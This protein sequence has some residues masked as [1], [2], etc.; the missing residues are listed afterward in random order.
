MTN[1]PSGYIIRS[2][3]KEDL[4]VMKK[5]VAIL[6]IFT[7]LLSLTGC[8]SYDGGDFD[9][10]GDPS[11]SGGYVDILGGDAKSEIA[12]APDGSTSS[13]D[14]SGDQ[15]ENIEIPS[16]M[17]TAG[18]WSDNDN[19]S[20]WLT[21][22]KQ[23]NGTEG[24]ENADDGKFFSYTK[25]NNSWGFDSQNR[26]S[27]SITSGDSA[28]AGA[29]VVARDKNGAELFRATSDASGKAYVFTSEPEGTLEIS[30]GDASATVD[31]TESDRDLIAELD[32][33]AEK[34][35][36]IELM[37]VLDVTGSMGDEI[38][39]LKAELADV[40][41][42]ISE[43]D[44]N[45]TIKLAMLFY[46]DTDDEVP[47]DYYDFTD[48]TT[49]EGMEKMQK[50]LNAQKAD[51]G[52]DYPEA[53]DEALRLA[54]SKQWSTGNTT[55]IIFHVLDAPA[56]TTTA[57]KEKFNAAVKTA[58]SRGIRICPVICSGAAELTEYT[59][60]E[61]AIH[62][63]GTFIFVTDDSGIGGEHHDPELPNVT[64]ELLNSMLV[65]LTMGYHIGSFESPIYWRDDP[66]LAIT[67]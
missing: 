15:N 44:K 12:T 60:R 1:A 37:L 33:A 52:G 39:F 5:T 11:A 35:N 55:K 59:M 21:L 31:F 49:D 19:Y 54:M 64:V 32:S 26:I 3:I 18:A 36:V 6:M 42:R 22:F 45:T 46:R 20:L 9:G 43:N 34:L 16:G 66:A 61:A 67:K 17:I 27:V 51:G 14:G 10:I 47:F 50:A 25:E 56:H 13:D 8:L 2:E 58:A 41:S 4:F 29:T 57:A 28:V 24:D 65:R 40:I 62:T 53:V 38:R 63:G 23:G 30:S 48:V 7:V